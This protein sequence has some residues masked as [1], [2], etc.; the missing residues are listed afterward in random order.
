MSTFS[1]HY[2]FT[3]IK[4][5]S[6]QFP[7]FNREAD[8]AVKTV[9]DLL[10]KC[11]GRKEDHYLAPIAYQVTPLERGYSPAEL[12]MSHMLPTNVPT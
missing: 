7:Q 4:V 1:N 9:K 11:D 12:L 5:Y 2:G 6:P 10:K 8:W 3:H